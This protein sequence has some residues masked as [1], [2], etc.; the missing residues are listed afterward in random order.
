MVS[1]LKEFNSKR[2]AKPKVWHY[3][4]PD[5]SDCPTPEGHIY[6]TGAAG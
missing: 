1:P 6:P 4:D 3:G 2:A 5:D